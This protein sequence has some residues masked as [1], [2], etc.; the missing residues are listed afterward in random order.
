[1]RLGRRTHGFAELS[2]EENLKFRLGYEF[3][4]E[5]HKFTVMF[6]GILKEFNVRQKLLNRIYKHISNFFFAVLRF[7]RTVYY[8]QLPQPFNSHPHPTLNS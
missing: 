2:K 3:E 5:I 8:V 6:F 4:K 1:M 7:Y